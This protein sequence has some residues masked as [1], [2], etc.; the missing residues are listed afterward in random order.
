MRTANNPHLF[1]AIPVPTP[2]QSVLAEW[3][4]ALRLRLPFRKWVHPA[5]YHLTLK[6]LGR[7]S[8]EQ[9]AN[10][11]HALRHL[12]LPEPFTLSVDRLGYF[13][14]PENPRVLWAGVTGDLRPLNHLQRRVAEQMDCLGFLKESRPY[15]PHVTLAKKFEGHAFPAASLGRLQ[16]PSKKPLTWQVDHIVLYQT[17]LARVPMYETVSVYPFNPNR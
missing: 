5:D 12:D 3:A 8:S 11:E 16:L 4:D 9:K 15:R 1:V 6:F 2:I 17:H 14:R 7:C 13:G 10:I